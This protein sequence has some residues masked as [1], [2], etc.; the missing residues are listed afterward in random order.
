M[1]AGIGN[2]IEWLDYKAI[3]DIINKVLG[4]G[5]G[6]FGYGQTVA[7]SPVTQYQKIT[8]TQWQNVRDDI[9]RCRMHQTGIDYSNSLTLSTKS[10]KLAEADR[11]AY[12][13]MATLAETNALAVAA[14][15]AERV[16]VSVSIYEDIW[17][18]SVGLVNTIDFGSAN[19]ARYFFNTGGQIDISSSRAGGTSPSPKNST[20]STMLSTMGS[21]IFNYTS[22]T[23]TGSSGTGSSLGYYD[24]STTDAKI[25]EQNAPTGTSYAANKY[26][27]NARINA[28]GSQIIFTIQ[29]LDLATYTNTTVFG[30]GLGPYGVD[31]YVDGTLTNTVKVYR[32]IQPTGVSSV[33]VPIPNVLTSNNWSV[34][35]GGSGSTVPPAVIVSPTTITNPQVEIA[36]SR[37]FTATG[38]VSPYIWSFTGGLPAGLSLNTST[39]VLSGTP[40]T[41]AGYSFSIFASD[42][43]GFVGSKN[44]TVQ[45]ARPTITVTPTTLTNPKVGTVYGVSFSATGGTGPYAWQSSGTLPPGL[46]L[47]T[48]GVLSGN[49]T[50]SGTYSFTVQVFDRFNAPGSRSYS[51]T[52][53][54]ASV[55][56]ITPTT[57]TG[58][59][60]GFS[61]S[62]Q[63]TASGGTAP[64]L[65]TSSGS[66][67]AGLLFNSSGLLSGTP[68]TQTSYNFNIIA[69]DA[70]PGAY[71][72]T[73]NYNVTVAA[74]E[75]PPVPVVTVSPATPGSM[76]VDV[77]YSRQYSAS[78]GTAPYTYS[79]VNVLPPGV[80]LSPGGLVSGTPSF[81]AGGKTYNY[82]I[83]ATD[84]GGYAGTRDVTI[85]VTAAPPPTT[86]I[87][88]T[89]ATQYVYYGDSFDSPAGGSIGFQVNCTANY[90]LVNMS[91]SSDSTSG[92]A[93]L[94]VDEFSISSGNSRT[95]LMNWAHARASVINPWRFRASAN[96][97]GNFVLT[98][99]RVGL[100][101]TSPTPGTYSGFVVGGT[102]FYDLAAS[103]GTSPYTFTQASGTLPPGWGVGNVSPLILGGTIAAGAARQTFI[104]G[105][106]VTD[107]NGVS[108][109]VQYTVIVS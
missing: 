88:P 47:S 6:T 13:N 35:Q 36:Y 85:T 87:S 60:V 94:N 28:T 66:I 52:V 9:L 77:A 25:F 27:I 46:S 109:T 49:P 78:G 43:T 33:E 44:Y 79:V 100:V 80:S 40:V 63:F 5:A 107:A 108:R 76:A 102:Y 45:V 50:T 30:P 98:V 23:R 64:Y 24:L 53:A 99:Q 70:S 86:N 72:R 73:N 92:T 96:T 81:G 83:R 68:T 10:V 37:T 8:E 91:A 57:I 74:P 16:T 62:R 32:A 14:T 2:K 54:A 20:W 82:G 39:G 21:V 4:T 65:W 75:L 11:L 15:Q 93:L 104:F 18:T 89:T 34:I 58:L 67:P 19:A 103:G 71:S 61:Y 106:R 22:T 51:V 31:E 48:G 29:Y 3:Q 90:G 95:V 1:A 26:V 69:T 41:A 56:S 105:V 38:G 7:S 84:Q 42:A 12:L 101:V 59:R 17:Y 55:I 97:G